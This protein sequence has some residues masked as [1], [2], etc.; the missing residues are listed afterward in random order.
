MLFLKKSLFVQTPLLITASNSSFL[1]ASWP[2]RSHDYCLAD[3][4]FIL[5][6]FKFYTLNFIVIKI[7]SLVHL[8]SSY[9]C[10]PHVI[11]V[12]I[13]F[14][15]FIFNHILISIIIWVIFKTFLILI[16]LGIFFFITSFFSFFFKNSFFGPFLEINSF[17]KLTIIVDFQPLH[18]IEIKFKSF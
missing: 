2:S 1:K 13:I 4:K 18:C 15:F 6:I 11:L 16:N 5:I 12:Q 7:Y 9:S 8:L 10:L 3:F 17:R 14:G